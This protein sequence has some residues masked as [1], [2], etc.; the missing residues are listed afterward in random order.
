MSHVRHAASARGARSTVKIS[1]LSALVLSLLLGCGSSNGDDIFGGG[2]G[3]GGRAASSGGAGGGAGSSGSSSGGAGGGAGSGGTTFGTCRDPNACPTPPG[4]V[5]CCTIDFHCGLRVGMAP[6]Y[7]CVTPDLAGTLNAKCPS[8]VVLDG[9][10]KGCC[11][12]N[13][14]CGFMDPSYGTGCVDPVELGYSAGKPCP[15]P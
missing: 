15:A 13:G 5:P 12:S 1:A 2:S 6:L 8:A 9:K 7:E 3:A 14:T 11:R 10:A 4:Q